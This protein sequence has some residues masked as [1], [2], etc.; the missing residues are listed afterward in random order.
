MEYVTRLYYT[1]RLFSQIM[2]HF[3]SFFASKCL[4]KPHL[5]W[6]Y[7]DA[8]TNDS[9]ATLFD[10][11][12]I[13]DQTRS[14]DE[15]QDLMRQQKVAYWCDQTVLNHFPVADLFSY[16]HIQQMRNAYRFQRHTPTFDP[17][18]F[19]VAVHIRRGD[20]AAYPTE[21]RYTHTDFF[22]TYINL[23]QSRYPFARF[24]VY[25]DSPL[26]LPVTAQVQYHILEDLL[27]TIH[28]MI[29]ADVLL[30]SVG[31]NMSFFA[32]LLTTG[33]AL[34][35]K[36]KL[37]EPFNAQ[38]NQ[39]WCKHPRFHLEKEAFLQSVEHHLKTRNMNPT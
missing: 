15:I 24:H 3:Y 1:D 8:Y 7:P 4:Q 23:L 22:T 38:D 18:Q 30:M 20:I 33:V 19:N 11:S 27:E 39:K 29:H 26:S 2:R 28:D 10:T 25:S 34:V 37:D 35:D 32:G 5:H 12:Q 16:D 6:P 9:F 21:S 14:Y 17:T 13:I 31:S 36:R